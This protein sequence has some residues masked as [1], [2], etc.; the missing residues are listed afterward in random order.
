VTG[1]AEKTPKGFI[2]VAK[3]PQTITHDQ[4]LTTCDEDFAQF[5]GTMEL[6]GD[7]LGPLLLQ[8]PYFNEAMS[9]SLPEFLAVL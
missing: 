8:F 3:V 7:K 2:F 4:V 6:L 5:V 1:W 9:K